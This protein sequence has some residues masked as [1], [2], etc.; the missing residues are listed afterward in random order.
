MYNCL[1]PTN[2]VLSFDYVGVDILVHSQNRAFLYCTQSSHMCSLRIAR[3]PC[4]ENVCFVYT[5]VLNASAM[6]SPLVVSRANCMPARPIL[7]I[8]SLSFS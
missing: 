4:P 2:R 3:L 7:L 6:P 8:S 5:Q 1:Q